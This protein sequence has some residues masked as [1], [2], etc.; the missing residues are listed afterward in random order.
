MLNKVEILNFDAT[1]FIFFFVFSSFYIYFKTQ[2]TSS[3]NALANS[4]LTSQSAV[5]P[6]LCLLKTGHTNCFHIFLKS[7]LFI[8]R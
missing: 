2:Y 1:Q 8:A 3:P 4:S 5:I 6:I 7:R